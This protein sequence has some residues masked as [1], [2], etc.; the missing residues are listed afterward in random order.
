MHMHTLIY[1]AA[2]A[3]HSKLK[4]PK[5]PRNAW[6]IFLGEYI[7]VRPSS[8]RRPSAS[9]A[10]A[11]KLGRRESQKH[12]T[13]TSSGEKV[14]AAVLSSRAAPEYRALSSSERAVYERQAADERAAYPDKLSAWMK[15]LTPEMIR[16]ENAIRARRRKAKLSNKRSLKLEGTPK[17][18]LSAFMRFVLP[19]FLLPLDEL[20]A[21]R[22]YAPDDE[23]LHRGRPQ[24]QH[25]PGAPALRDERGR[26]VKADRPGVEGTARGRARVVRPSGQGRLCGVQRRK[27]GV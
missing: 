18:P 1:R 26:S 21:D 15:T 5:A 10:R 6:S 12:S 4:P 20:S 7:E 13:T 17:R 14:T 11:L 27:E 9:S 8:R 24:R 23:Q 19:I 2:A 22:G 25:P 3:M 16:E